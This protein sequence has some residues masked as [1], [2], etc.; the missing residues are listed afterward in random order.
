VREPVRFAA[1][2]ETLAD[3]GATAFLELGPEAVLSALG[4]Q[5]LGADAKAAFVPTL[6]EGSEEP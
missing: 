6:R 1:A 2:V 3:Q 5:C 4:P